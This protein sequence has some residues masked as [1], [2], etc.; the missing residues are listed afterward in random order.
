MDDDGIDPEPV[1]VRVTVTKWEDF[2]IADFSASDRQRRGAINCACGSTLSAAVNALIRVADPGVPI[3]QGCF[4][5]LAIVAPPGTVVNVEFPGASVAGHTG[6]SNH[7]VSAMIRALAPVIPDRVIGGSID[8]FCNFT[9]GGWDPRTKEHYSFYWVVHGGWGAR[10]SKDGISPSGGAVGNAQTI[11]TEILE[12]R[13]PWMVEDVSFAKDSGGPGTYRGGLGVIRAFRLL[14]PAARV[15]LTSDR[16]IMRPWG[17]FGGGNGQGTQI[18]LRR[19]GTRAP[20]CDYGVRFPTKFMNLELHEG[21][22]LVVQSPGGGGYGYPLERD[23]S[24]V[25]RDVLEGYV[26]IDSARR[27]Y[28]VVIDPDTGEVDHAATTSLRDSLRTARPEAP[29]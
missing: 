4:R 16:H 3:N 29:A 21:D 19:N 5:S 28:G 15:S 12:V 10:A 25:S 20:I 14:A 17:I 18:N 8:G 27:D 24:R 2:I 6:L 22:T 13:H 26:T 9:G 23:P 7:I 1:T 11:A